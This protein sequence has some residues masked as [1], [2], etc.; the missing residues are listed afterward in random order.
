[1]RIHHVI[2]VAA[3]FVSLPLA[4]QSNDVGIW[5]SSAKLGTTNTAGSSAAFDNAR[6]YGIS[7]NRF[8]TGSLSTEFTAD[9]LKAKGG[10]DV[11]GA[12]ALNFDK[13]KIMPV[14]ADVQWHFLRGTMF[15]PYIGAGVA[16][17]KMDDITGSDLDVAGFGPIKVDHKFTWNGNVGLNVGLGRMFAIGL[18]YKYIK[19]E[20]TATSALGSEKLKLDPKQFSAGL[21]LRF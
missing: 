11:A 14:T 6:G 7:Y 20:P 2:L 21:K 3:L 13:T 10:I 8:W 18:D 4:A 15:S 5:Y 9:W 16:Y 12:R 17:V 1:M 19:F